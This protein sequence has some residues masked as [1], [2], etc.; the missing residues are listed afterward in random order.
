MTKTESMV[1]TDQSKKLKFKEEN[2]VNVYKQG[3]G[4]KNEFM[5]IEE[6]KIDEDNR[7]AKTAFENE[8]Y[9]GDLN[10]LDK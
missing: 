6:S 5:T 7:W 9:S 8:D 10:K 3:E 4:Q 2:D 1:S